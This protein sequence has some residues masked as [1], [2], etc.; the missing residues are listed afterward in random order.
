MSARKSCMKQPPNSASP[1]P[2]R[3]TP[4]DCGS[5]FRRRHMGKV[6]WWCRRFRWHAWFIGFAPYVAQRGETKQIAFAILVE[7]GQY[8]GASAA[9]MASEIVAAARELGL[10]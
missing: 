8:G 4:R 3:T 9:P 5:C 7:N 6:K 10:L 1:W 2:D